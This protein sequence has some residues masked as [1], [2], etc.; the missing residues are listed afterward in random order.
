VSAPTVNLTN[1]QSQA[2]DLL[3]RNVAASAAFQQQAGVYD[4]DSLLGTYVHYPWYRLSN[5]QV[6]KPFAVIY[7]VPGGYQAA[8]P[9]RRRHGSQRRRCYLQLGINDAKRRR[10]RGGRG[11]VLQQLAGG[12][13]RH[14]R[15]RSQIPGRAPLLLEQ[16]T[17][18]TRSHPAHV[19]ALAAQLPFWFVE[20]TVNWDP[21]L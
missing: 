18:P 6:D 7:E 9:G 14:V 1:E 2:I 10:S 17:P 21:F 13:R 4:V 12:R 5:Q 20:Y 19:A 8:P 11:P 15:D 16:S 3:A